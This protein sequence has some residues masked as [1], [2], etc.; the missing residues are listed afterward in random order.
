MEKIFDI[1][2][3]SE[4]SWGVIAQGIDGN[5]TELEKKRMSNINIYGNN[6]WQSLGD[7]SKLNNIYTSARKMTRADV[8]NAIR[9]AKFKGCSPSEKRTI[10]V[11][12][13]NESENTNGNVR[14]TK[15][16]EESSSW[17]VEFIYTGVLSEN[18]GKD[19]N[20]YIKMGKDS[21]S[22]ELLIDLTNIPSGVNPQLN[23]VNTTPEFIFSE[24]CYNYDKN[25][26]RPQKNIRLFP[27]TKLPCLSFSFDDINVNDRQIV[28]LFDKYGVTCGFGYVADYL[29]LE[30]SSDEYLEYQKKGYSILNHSV[31]GLA[32]NNTN[33]TYET[34]L[35]TIM[36]AKN[37]LEKNGFIVN[38]F[39][40]PSSQIE[41]SFLPMLKL[42]HA[43]AY[44]SAATQSTQNGR[45]QDTCQLH[46]YAIQSHTL[47]E[48][49]AFVDD[50]IEHD[51]ITTFYGHSA[52]FGKT[53]NEEE[54]NI[55]KVEAI[56][57]YV[58]Q[59]RDQGVL[60]LGNTD[61]CV[62]YF[63]DL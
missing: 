38:G 29:K 13:N 15:Y 56:L 2:K 25:Y 51:Q 59:K 46:R 18:V 53:F 11:I 30:T 48:I 62:K 36:E 49:K 17:V 12:W 23:P 35:A 54:W 61:E 28:E 63:F 55:E 40:A 3:D 5:F 58:I 42:S 7:K 43:Y 47:A 32:F 41:E 60:W 26:H 21:K 20:V 39:V 34:A 4:K 8:Y 9:F 22:C 57:N 37:I 31:D 10:F 52:D 44:T 27:Q 24:I 45:Q 33:Y 16:D 6:I 1:A 14:I 50:C 19:G